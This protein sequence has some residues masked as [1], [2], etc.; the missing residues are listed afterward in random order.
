MS[1]LVSY[2]LALGRSP[3]EQC[4]MPAEPGPS[5]SHMSS[6]QLGK[7]GY[8]CMRGCSGT[9]GGRAEGSGFNHSSHTARCESLSHRFVNEERRN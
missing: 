6:K 7:L 4:S 2:R 9:R 1:L 5:A 8:A 3:E